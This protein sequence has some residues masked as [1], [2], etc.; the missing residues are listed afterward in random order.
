MHVQTGKLIHTLLHYSITPLSPCLA[1]TFS[2]NQMNPEL[3]WTLQM[4]KQR[5]DRQVRELYMDYIALVSS[6]GVTVR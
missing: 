6:N 1:F 4:I 3:K 2:Y 5:R